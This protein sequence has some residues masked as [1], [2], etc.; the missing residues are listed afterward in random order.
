MVRLCGVLRSV[1]TVKTMD[2]LEE[3]VRKVKEAAKSVA[4]VLDMSNAKLISTLLSAV[5]N[6][7]LRELEIQLRREELFNEMASLSSP[8]FAEA[9]QMKTDA[10][11]NGYGIE[12]ELRTTIADDN[13]AAV[14]ETSNKPKARPECFIAIVITDEAKRVLGVQ[15]NMYL[16]TNVNFEVVTASL[17]GKEFIQVR[18]VKTGKPTLMLDASVILAIDYEYRPM[19]YCV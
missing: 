19:T 11:R 5:L 16:F 2:K 4:D 14:E 18:E 17:R 7:A 10:A 8:E 3:A 9:V 12:N 15:S 1:R 13:N 6:A